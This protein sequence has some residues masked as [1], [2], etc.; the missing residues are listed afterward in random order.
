MANALQEKVPLESGSTW[1]KNKHQL[2]K[3]R[4]YESCEKVAL[5]CSS[6]PSYIILY[7]VIDYN[8]PIQKMFGLSIHG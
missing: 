5:K 7:Y 4:Y 1:H 2:G 3:K 6:V 8:T